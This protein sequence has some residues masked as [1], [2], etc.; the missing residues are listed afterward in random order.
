MIA[1]GVRFLNN[2]FF[3]EL[4]KPVSELTQRLQENGILTPP[5]QITLDNARTV[6][7]EL[8]PN[9]EM[10]V[11][12]LKLVDKKKDTLGAIN[13]L[14]YNV[15]RLDDRRYWKFRDLVTKGKVKSVSQG[16]SLFSKPRQS[17]KTK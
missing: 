12:L 17:E 14:C 1:V 3:A 10:G 9:D 11:L 6:K 8:Y 7:V 16:L 5:D 13:R 4:T 2:S 15:N